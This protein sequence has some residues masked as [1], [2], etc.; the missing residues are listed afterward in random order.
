MDKLKE[1]SKQW[2]GD[3]EIQ[4]IIREF[5]LS[6]QIIRLYEC[7]FEESINLFS[8]PE[9]L[10]MSTMAMDHQKFTLMDFALRHADDR[11]IAMLTDAG[12]LEKES[13]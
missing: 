9:L 1:V 3:N 10:I 8:A 13:I 4:F 6:S 2:L 11:F 12:L 7:G 5:A